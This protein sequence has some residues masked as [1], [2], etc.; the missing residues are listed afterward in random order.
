MNPFTCSTN[1]KDALKYGFY[2]LQSARDWYR[3]VTSDVGMHAN[4]VKYWIRVQAILA[5]PIAPHFAEHVYSVILQ[6]PT[7][8]QLARWPTPKEPVDHTIIEAIAYMR[9]TVK[10]ARDADVSLKKMLRKANSKKD[11]RIF[12]PKLPKSLRI[13]VATSFP[14]WQDA[15]VQIIKE[16]YDEQ[17]DKVNDVKVKDLLAQKGLMKDKKVMPF[18]QAFKVIS[19]SHVSGYGI[20]DW[21]FIFVEMHGT[22][23]RT[24]RFPSNPILRRKSGFERDCA[25]HQ[26]IISPRRCGNTLC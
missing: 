3:E 20:T 6:S 7:S 14:V 5:S 12:D 13:Y 23:R 11:G 24:D 25:T 8:I 9:S 2:E 15:C 26:E 19:C 18:V 4:L 17:S 22:V 16:A 1:Y 10:S 21:S